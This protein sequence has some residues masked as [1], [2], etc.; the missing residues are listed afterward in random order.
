MFQ[1]QL[2]KLWRS[3][4]HIDW[5]LVGSLIPIMGAGLLTMNSF[6]GA[7][8]LFQ[9]QLLWITIS[10]VVFFSLIQV[11][12]QFLR[13]TTVITSIFGF[14]IFLLL[15]LFVLGS[16][17][18]GANS[19]FHIGAVAFEPADLAKLSLILLLSK[20]FSTRHIEIANI[21]HILVSGFY[22]GIVFVLVA[23]QP[24]FGSALVA[25]LIWIGMV[26][27]SG[28]SKKHLIAA[29]FL[30]I[31]SFSLLWSF[32][33][34]QYQK[35]RILTF[36]H[37][38]TDISGKGYNA[39]QSM[40]AVGSGQLLGKGVGYGTQSR[41]QFLPEYQTDFIFAAFAEEWGFF[42]SLIIVLLYVTFIS[43]LLLG[44][45]KG[46]TNFEVFFGIG[47][48]ILFTSHIM[49]NMGMNI[50]LLPVTG[51]PIPFMS[52]GGTHLLLSF[53][54]LGIFM[55]M[56]QYARPAGRDSMGNEFLGF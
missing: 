4:A 6:S 20:Y 27:V 25:A 46:A 10:L 34:K 31:I 44:A 2:K 1:E 16:V 8:I 50:G 37:P 55:G 3:V 18:K 12:F 53:V 35:D 30:A 36:V 23:V 26:F 42:G 33:F 47:L 49:I 11:N 5:I 22:A 17:V 32:G 48:A 41:L 38:L 24:D 52:Y 13:S 54:G 15:A 43:R 21:R 45:M 9:K 7:N 14:S 39:Y 29:T 19:W 28:I 51:I 56:R 40:V